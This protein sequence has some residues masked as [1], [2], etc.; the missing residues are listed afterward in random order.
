MQPIE[1]FAEGMVECERTR[2][3]HYAKAV[4]EDDDEHFAM[5]IMDVGIANLNIYEAAWF[6]S[7]AKLIHDG[8]IIGG[9]PLKEFE[10]CGDPVF[11]GQG[12]QPRQNRVFGKEIRNWGP[13]HAVCKA[14]RSSLW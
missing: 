4:G 1:Q 3:V 13:Q 9:E 5:A 6:A 8:L 2:F 12:Q 11:A 7:G 14:A 10:R